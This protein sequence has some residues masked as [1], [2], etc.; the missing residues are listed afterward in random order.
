MGLTEEELTYLAK[1]G[2]HVIKT[3]RRD[4][5]IIVSKGLDG[6]TTVS[7]TMYIASLAKIKFCYWWNWRCASWC[8]NHNGYFGRFR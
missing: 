8:G 1:S 7:A 4:I 2:S 3:S 6:A 5:P